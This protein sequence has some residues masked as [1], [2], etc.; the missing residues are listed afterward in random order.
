MVQWS[1]EYAIG[2][3]KIDEQHKKLFEIANK[4][5]ELLKNPFFTDKYDKI[6]VIIKELKDY[7]KYHFDY[8]EKYMQ[9]IG[10]KKYFSQK[11]AHNECVEKINKFDLK[12]IDNNQDEAILNLLEFI[13]SW[14]SSHIKEEDTQIAKEIN[15]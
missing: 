11:V 12:H 8:E 9:S 14:I 7:T 10:Y 6:V 5:Y 1:E 2:I 4:A 15:K 3:E 13:V